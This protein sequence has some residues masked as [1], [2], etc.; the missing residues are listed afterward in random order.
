MDIA[1][2]LK[3]LR[4][5]LELSQREMAKKLEISLGGLQSYE[6]GKSVPGGNVL[7]ALARLGF[8]VNWL[9]TGEGEMKYWEFERKIPR[10][11]ADELW[12]NVIQAA[13]ESAGVEDYKSGEYAHTAID[14][15]GL[16][17][18]LRDDLPTIDEIKSMF[19][20]IIML[21]KHL[22]QGLS[23]FN[24]EDIPKLIELAIKGRT[25]KDKQ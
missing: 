1:S 9:L 25:I 12:V 7:E 15:I 20:V 4:E 13:L 10:R 14:I 17:A 22:E 19:S 18:E 23:K 8:N 3:S 11:Y 16:V 21:N 6:S 24:R 5:S 2:R